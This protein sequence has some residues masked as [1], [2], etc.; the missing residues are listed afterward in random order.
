MNEENFAPEL[1]TVTDENGE[2]VLNEDGE[3]LVYAQNDKYGRYELNKTLT[4]MKRKKE[5]NMA[6]TEEPISL[7]LKM[8]FLSKTL[9]K[10][11][12]V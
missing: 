12:I 8:I 1:L 5:K 6:T 3:F 9:L 4:L 10:E 2:R 7:K 11:K